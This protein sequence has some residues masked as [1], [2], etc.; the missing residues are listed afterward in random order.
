MLPQLFETLYIYIYISYSIYLNVL[1][2]LPHWWVSQHKP[3]EPSIGHGR[4]RPINCWWFVGGWCRWHC[5]ALVIHMVNLWWF[6]KISGSFFLSSWGLRTIVWWRLWMNIVYSMYTPLWETHLGWRSENHGV[7]K[8][9]SASL[10]HRGLMWIGGF[11]HSWLF[12]K[13]KFT[14]WST[15]ACI[16]FHHDMSIQHS[17]RIYI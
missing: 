16:V 12:P 15:W 2:P 11:N 8:W 4:W 10:I 1:I 7:L 5:F 14:Q 3:G 13:R 6:N 9:G 17:S